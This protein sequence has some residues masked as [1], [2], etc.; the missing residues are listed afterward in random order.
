LPINGVIL[1]PTVQDIVASTAGNNSHLFTNPF[2]LLG[3]PD[4]VL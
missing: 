2:P 4:E 3:R 1:G